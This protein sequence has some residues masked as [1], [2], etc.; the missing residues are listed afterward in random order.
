M[1]Q[2][3]PYK[4][5]P[6]QGGQPLQ[7]P[8]QTATPPVN[9]RPMPNG[10]APVGA[11]Q[12]RRVSPLPENPQ[13]RAVAPAPVAAESE[14]PRR[15]RSGRPNRE[16]LSPKKRFLY[17]VLDTVKVFCVVL[18]VYLL[19]N[20]FVFQINEVSGSSMVPTLHTGDRIIVNLI[21]K[22]LGGKINRGDII[23]I[24]AGELDKNYKDIIKRV[25]GLP[26]DSVLI[27]NE[28]V[29]INGQKLDEPY[30]GPLVR[31]APKGMGHDSVKLGKDEY[32]VMGDNRE[33]SSDSRDIGP[34]PRK[35]IMGEMIFRFYPFSDF[36]TVK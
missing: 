6:Q 2:N 30:L 31:T 8:R 33:D 23:T 17:D 27:T 36:G 1:K 10:A 9:Y 28:G 13:Q 12:T 29:F 11:P 16:D 3:R 14:K 24:H 15:A 34:I 4:Q 21:G 22:T 19:L 7:Y 5:E 18:V 26:G 35:A 32:Y 25:I 20:H